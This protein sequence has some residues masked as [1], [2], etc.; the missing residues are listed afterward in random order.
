[1]AAALALAALGGS[2]ALGETVQVGSVL[3]AF[4]GEINPLRLPRDKLV[5]ATLRFDGKIATTDE[6]H[7]PPL[8]TLALELNRHGELTTDG[9][10]TCTAAQLKT[11]LTNQAKQVCGDALIGSGNASAEIA[12]P[13]QAPFNATGPLLIFNSRNAR[14]EE[15]L[16]FHVYAHVPAPT[17]FVTVGKIGRNPKTGRPTIAIRIP[18][19]VSG[20]GSLTGFDAIFRRIVGI[21]CPA[22]NNAPGAVFKFASAGLKFRNG[23]KVSSTLVRQCKVKG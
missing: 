5:P 17:T 21:D 4:E 3:V 9:I 10:P 7:V 20:Q 13:E 1:M 6:T 23:T 15:Q 19:I 12:L 2:S 18:T 16:L 11:T 14:G 22:P 8:K